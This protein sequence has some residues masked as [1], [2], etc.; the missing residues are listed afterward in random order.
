MGPTRDELIKRMR[1]A[2]SDFRAT[3]G[4]YAPQAEVRFQDGRWVL[5]DLELD[6]AAA[7]AAGK[8]ALAEGKGWMPENE[9]AYLHPGAVVVEAATKEAFIEKL[10]KIDWKY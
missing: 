4:R 7:Q 5:V 9:F 6:R 2:K 10:K 3:L 8:K 1:K